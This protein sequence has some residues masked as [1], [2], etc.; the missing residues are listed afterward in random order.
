MNTMKANFKKESFIVHNRK[1]HYG[2]DAA[3]ISEIFQEEINKVQLNLSSNLI[4]HV[5]MENQVVWEDICDH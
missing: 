4:H 1:S 2:D 3:A 5:R